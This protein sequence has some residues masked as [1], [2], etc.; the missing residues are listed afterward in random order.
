M[1]NQENR[2]SFFMILLFVLIVIFYIIIFSV[3]PFIY[4]ITSAII[5]IILF[6][7]GSFVYFI[8]KKQILSFEL[9]RFLRDFV[10]T[11][12]FGKVFFYGTKASPPL[13]EYEKNG[14]IFELAKGK[15]EHIDCNIQDDLKLY[16]IIPRE[17]GGA[18]TSNNLIVLCP[19]HYAMA[20]KGVLSKGLLKYFI[21]QRDN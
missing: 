18:N 12:S 17:E 5:L 8:K 3:I 4:F 9:V 13:T 16:Y 14:V 10:K 21:K 20:D 15:C 11:I 6:I 7:V 1:G 2:I 19:N